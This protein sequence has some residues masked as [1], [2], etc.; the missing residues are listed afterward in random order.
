MQ[1]LRELIEKRYKRWVACYSPYSQ[2]MD[3]IYG[4]GMIIE[5]EDYF[6]KEVIYDFELYDALVN[7]FPNVK[8]HYATFYITYPPPPEEDLTFF[9]VEVFDLYGNSLRSAG[10]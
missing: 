4:N 3:I 9:E 8:I 2:I 5:K 7:V 1:A 6:I 10:L